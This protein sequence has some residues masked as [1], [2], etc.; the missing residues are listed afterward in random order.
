LNLTATRRLDEIS[1]ALE[2]T[3]GNQYKKVELPKGGSSKTET[4][5]SAGIDIRRANEAEKLAKIDEGVFNRQS[6]EKIGCLYVRQTISLES[7]DICHF[8]PRKIK[9]PAFPRRIQCGVL[10]EYKQGFQ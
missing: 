10:H 2:K 1:A 4:L 5:S 9:R 6:K 3:K 8:L 7:D